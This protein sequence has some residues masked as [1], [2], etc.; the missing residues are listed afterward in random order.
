M[1]QAENRKELTINSLHASHGLLTFFKINF[2]KKFFQEHYQSVKRF[3]ARAKSMFR[4]SHVQIQ[5]VLSGGSKFDR[6][7]FVLFFY[8]AGG[9]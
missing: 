4:R 8:E 1:F 7:F 2:F 3:G 6:F 5:K 9:S